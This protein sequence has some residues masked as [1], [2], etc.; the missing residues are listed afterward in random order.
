MAEAIDTD[1][2][3]WD[4]GFMTLAGNMLLQLNCKMTQCAAIVVLAS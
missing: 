4:A 1:A 3:T 2:D